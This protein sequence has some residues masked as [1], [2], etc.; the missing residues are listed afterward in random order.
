MT[1]AD[2]M[3]DDF[4]DFLY[5]SGQVGAKKESKLA[6]R[7]DV[8]ALRRELGTPRGDARAMV[9]GVMRSCCNS[10]LTIALL[11][12]D[13]TGVTSRRHGHNT[14]SRTRYGRADA[15]CMVRQVECSA[16]SLCCYLQGVRRLCWES[17]RRC[18][19]AGVPH[20]SAIHASST[21]ALSF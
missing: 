6:L 12:S 14:V 1:E 8:A 7:N 16:L 19:A 5:E 20:C 11:S 17:R 4:A 3:T 2:E 21:G 18:C 15:W 10:Q 13:R 9:Q